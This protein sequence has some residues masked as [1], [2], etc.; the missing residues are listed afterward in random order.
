[1]RCVSMIPPYANG[2]TCSGPTPYLSP[3]TSADEL[4]ETLQAVCDGGY[5]CG[6]LGYRENV[7]QTLDAHG[8]KTILVFRDPRDVL[9][10]TLHF[11]ETFPNH[12]L[13]HFF[14]QESCPEK[15]LRLL[16][17]GSDDSTTFPHTIM[18]FRDS[19][20]A[21]LHWA[22]FGAA[23]TVRY[24]RLV[25]PRGGG[26]VSEQAAELARIAEFLQVD[27]S[28]SELAAIGEFAYSPDD[29]T[30]R[31]GTIGNW[32]NYDSVDVERLFAGR[33]R[34]LIDDWGYDSGE[35]NPS[36]STLEIRHET[37]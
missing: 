4:T 10:S 24:E 37:S 20:A 6:H 15:K 27:L 28:E 19:Y 21:L 32:R 16:L 30:F 36:P 8:I 25:G 22:N 29:V 18:G 34:K 23:L 3:D 1:M 2:V 13:H 9:I 12:S 31:R 14:A 33:E 35:R 17:F 5:F 7:C 11:V 26:C